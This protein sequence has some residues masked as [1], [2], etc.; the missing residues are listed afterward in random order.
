MTRWSRWGVLATTSGIVIAGVSAQSATAGEAATVRASAGSLDADVVRPP[1]GERVEG[2]QGSSIVADAHGLLVAERNAGALVRADASGAPLSRLELAP[3]LGQ[4]V[5]DA[6]GRVFV[7]DRGADRIVEV[8]PGDATVAPSIVGSV[9]VVEPHGVALTPDGKTLLVTSVADQELVAIATKDLSIAWRV[10]LAPEP[11]GVAVS[12]SGDRAIVGFLATGAVAVVELDAKGKKVRWHA[13]DPRDH[14]GVVKS[15]EEFD[16]DEGELVEIREAPSRF[17]V[18]TDTGRRFARGG[19]AVAFVGNDRAIV[20]HEVAIP[21]LVSKPIVESEDSYGGVEA[22][23]PI[24][25]HLA[26]V[27]KPGS[28]RARVESQVVSLHQPRAV[29]YDAG[30]DVLY[31]AG[32]GDDAVVALADASQP[33]PYVAWRARVGERAACGVDGLALAESTVFVHCELARAVIPIDTARLEFD[34]EFHLE[35]TWKRGPELAKS[36]RSPDVERGAEV[37][38]R[39]N[40]FSLSQEGQLACASCHPEGRSDGL[41]WRL[42]RSILQTPML[43]GRVA[44]TAPYKWDGQDPDLR[45]SIEHT[46]DRIGGDSSSVS[47]RDLRALEAFVGSL[48]APRSPTVR[49]ADALARGKALFEGDALKCATCHSGGSLTDGAQY[50]LASALEQSDTPS[51]VG[52]AH[53][54]PYY[55]DGSAEDLWALVTDKGS[56][57]DMA[58]LSGLSVAQR[59]DLHTYLRSL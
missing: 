17:Q 19:F 56:V 14:V 16:M 55:H 2:G 57:H 15:D 7:A 44:N 10:R 31:V 40:D 25:H 46:I 48:P 8:A 50:P 58:D 38:R 53:T 3:G 28:P 35:T 27:A 6:G 30:K 59:E 39:A 5:R 43:A 45:H 26:F 54:A 4:L 29:A 20:P 1:A 41:N 32:Y 34:F 52:L 22:L 36:L 18:P 33:A 42:G 47:R 13:L 49:D 9:G 23:S 21:Q 37:F 11:R 24:S 12:P 51:L